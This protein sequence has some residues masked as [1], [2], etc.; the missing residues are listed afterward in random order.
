MCLWKETRSHTRCAPSLRRTRRSRLWRWWSLTWIQAPST[1]PG[2]VRSSAHRP[3]LQAAGRRRYLH[4]ILIFIFLRLD[5]GRGLRKRDPHGFELSFECMCLNYFLWRSW[6]DYK[7]LKARVSIFLLS[8]EFIKKKSGVRLTIRRLKCIWSKWN[9]L[10]WVASLEGSI[11]H[12]MIWCQQK[13][14]KLFQHILYVWAILCL[15]LQQQMEIPVHQYNTDWKRTLYCVVY[16]NLGLTWKKQL[17]R[18]A[19]I[20]CLQKIKAWSRLQSYICHIFSLL[21][22]LFGLR[23]P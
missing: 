4:S 19:F 1:R 18:S 20:H 15:C 5:F 10:G 7:R 21:S 12:L 11:S 23:S 9:S 13:S 16:S 14:D 8:S 2:Q 3:A 17:V 22:M 6:F